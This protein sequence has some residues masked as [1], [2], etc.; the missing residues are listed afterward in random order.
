MSAISIPTT[1]ISSRAVE[2]SSTA[3]DRTSIAY[4]LDIELG[5]N[6]ASVGIEHDRTAFQQ[7][8]NVGFGDPNQ[9]QDIDATSVVAE[10]QGLAARLNW[11][12]SARFDSNSEFDDAVNGRLA[13]T[14]PLGD[15]T[16][17]RGSVGTGQKNPTFIELYGF[18]P[19]GHSGN[20]DLKPERSVS[21]ELGL[22]QTFANGRADL[23]VA[24]FRQDLSDEINGFVFD[25]VTFLTSAQNMDGKSKRSG[26]ELSL[27][28]A[29]HDNVNLNAHYTYTDSTAPDFS[30]RDAREVRRP[31]HSGGIGINYLLPSQ[32]FSASLTA[33][34]GGERTDQFFP[35][36]PNPSEIVTL[37]SYWLVDLALKFRLTDNVSLYAR[38]SNLLNED[39][40]HVVGYATLGRAGY[41]GV[42]LRFD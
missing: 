41:A 4:Q 30:G 20:P 22:R 18:F 15:D 33:D 27:R 26:G 17:L 5:E 23:D 24:L 34:Y 40:E 38:G 13:L 25:P 11:I 42:R 35:P 6:R 39:Y 31:R 7:R 16:T 14:Y 2:D 1:K 8:G 10:Y 12:V 9:D 37:D 32:R 19:A 36:F 21:W 29:L 28:W 3:S